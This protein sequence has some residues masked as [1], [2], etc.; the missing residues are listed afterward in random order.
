M[1]FCF[2]K[3]FNY[4]KFFWILLHKIERKNALIC[5]RAQRFDITLAHDREP[6]RKVPSL[7]NLEWW[8]LSYFNI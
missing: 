8:H 4:R 2:A 5:A 3:I 1:L 6:E 7:V